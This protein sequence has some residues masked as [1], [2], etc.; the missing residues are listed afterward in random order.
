MKHCASVL[1]SLLLCSEQVHSQG[2]AWHWAHAAG[3]SGVDRANGTCADADGNVFITGYFTS[4]GINLGGTDLDNTQSNNTADLF[5]AKVAPDGTFLWVQQIGGTG[6]QAGVAVA[7]TP[8]GQV[9]LTGTFENSITVGSVVLLSTGGIDV[10]VAKYTA[11]GVPMWATSMGG[12]EQDQ[13]TDVAVHTD[14]TVAVVGHYYSAAFAAGAGSL[15]NSA[16]GD[17]DLFVAQLDPFG[18]V[19]W[20]RG[21]GGIY[22]DVAQSVAMAANGQLVVGGFFACATLELGA[23]ELVNPNDNVNDLFLAR[24]DT[25]GDVLWAKR[26]GGTRHE[27]IWGVGVHGNGDIVVAG[28]FVDA[29]LDLDGT[30]LVNTT[31]DQSWYDLFVARYTGDGDLL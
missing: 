25:N 13:V 31:S 14:G 6:S 29:T 26:A 23:F 3:G 21:G 9:V 20:V 22:D 27:R 2:P 10:F 30:T 17:A 11:A 1:V 4:N 7:A 16:P 24:Y 15:E 12:S 28:S 19:Q 8:Q 18:T 5:L